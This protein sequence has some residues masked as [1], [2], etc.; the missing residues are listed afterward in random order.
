MNKEVRVRFAPSPTGFLHIGGARTAIFNWIFARHNRGKFLLRIED[1]DK[2]RSTQ[3]YFDAILSSLKWLGI[4]WDEDYTVQSGNIDLHRNEVSRLLESGS[5][6]K[7]FCPPEL[8]EKKKNEAQKQ[9]LPEKYDRTC[10]EL[11]GDEIKELESN[12]TPCVIRFR[13]PEG[14]TVFNDLIHGKTV[15][16]NCEIDDFV[17]LRADDTPTYQFAVVV[18]DHNMNITHIIRGND[19]LSN[20]PKQIMLFNAFGWDVP[21]FA[22]MPMIL[23]QDKTRLSKRHGAVSLEHYR[24]LGYLPEAVFNYLTLLGWSPGNDREVVSKEEIIEKFE[25]SDTSKKSAVFD[26]VKL[27]WINNQ[28]ITAMD[29]PELAELIERKLVQDIELGRLVEEIGK[30]YLFQIL[31]LQRSRLR[32]LTDFIPFAGYFYRD[33]VTY[34]PAAVKK[35]WLKNTP[36]VLE[37]LGRMRLIMKECADYTEEGIEQDIRGL[38]EEIDISAAKLIHPTRLALTGYGVSPGLFELMHLLGQETVIRR[39]EKAV[40]Y[41]QTL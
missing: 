5:V 34:D 12:N 30:D 10:L 32:L 40:T 38:A 41:L 6:Y 14:E 37:R 8:L 16:Q 2:K 20:T 3:E 1:T 13:V 29:I 25:I 4:D 7:C 31:D 11:S 24:E 39:L 26:E 15:F 33:P 21:D 19:H 18:D 36:D 17:I 22:H 27:Q 35:H 23:G 28:Y 9:K